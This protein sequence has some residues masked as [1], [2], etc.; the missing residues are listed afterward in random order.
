MKGN[1]QSLI[2][3]ARLIRCSQWIKNI[4]VFF[5]LFF[6]HKILDLELLKPCVWAVLLFCLLSSAVYCFNDICDW[7]TDRLHP[8]K[9]YRPLAAGE[10]S[11]SETIVV[12]VVFLFLA[13]GG[14]VALGLYKLLYV[15]IAYVVLNV[16][17]SSWLKR[18]AIVDV[19]VLALFYVMRLIAG[20]V[21]TGVENS[22]WIILM[23]FLL[24][25]LLGLGKRRDD[26]VKCN[27]TNTVLRQSTTSYSLSFVNVSMGIVG[28]VTIVC[29]I[30][31][32]VS[33]EV[34]AHV[35]SHYLY[36]TSLFVLA[37]VLRYLQLAICN[38]ESGSPTRLMWRDHFLQIC[39][40]CWF[41]CFILLLYL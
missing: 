4:F 36:V 41:G 19:L 35:G 23:T 29:Y 21:V 9:R 34:M 3:L 24:A 2:T 28:S 10:V 17:Y 14:C 16:L 37:S 6:G 27:E 18:I 8:V 40:V 39:V 22:Q 5:P 31:Y 32:T 38:G 26:M 13:L 30:M 33:E 25:L 11:L 20:S 7:K 15:F 1:K 12:M